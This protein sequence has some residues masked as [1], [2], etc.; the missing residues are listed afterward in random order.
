MRKEDCESGDEGAGGGGG[1][2]D[3]GG[4][5]GGGGAK[6]GG[7]K[8]GGAKGG[9]AKGA[10]ESSIGKE[11]VGEAGGG[12]VGEKRREKRKA[13]PTDRTDVSADDGDVV[14]TRKRARGE[15]YSRAKV[16][17]FWIHTIN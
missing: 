12:A 3:E 15:V 8:G 7:A 16:G 14:P 13:G 4:G 10:E 11:R 2:G 9:G 5:G 6:G 1:G 17:D